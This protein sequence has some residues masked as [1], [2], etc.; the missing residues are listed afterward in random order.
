MTHSVSPFCTHLLSNI[1][2]T[3]FLA[4][5]RLPPGRHISELL[6]HRARRRR[7]RRRTL[8][9]RPRRQRLHASHPD[10]LSVANEDHGIFKYKYCAL[11]ELPISYFP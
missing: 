7:G 2:E 3:C 4:D 10:R 8:E 6:R 9:A 11:V 5:V 1:S